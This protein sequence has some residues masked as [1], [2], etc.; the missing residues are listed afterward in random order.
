MGVKNIHTTIRDTL[1]ACRKHD[2]WLRARSPPG[3]MDSGETGANQHS[4]P[5]S[6]T[7]WNRAWSRDLPSANA[8]GYPN[9]RCLATL[10]SCQRSSLPFETKA[11]F[12]LPP[13]CRHRWLSEV[14]YP[15][16]TGDPDASVEVSLVYPSVGKRWIL[17]P[18]HDSAQHPRQRRWPA[19]A[20]SSR[21]SRLQ[22]A[23]G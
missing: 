18:A 12:D 4:D 10:L 3:L 8:G 14:P 23:T 22:I 16:G 1:L 13:P 19:R 21:V 7:D 15:Q 5:D 17:T 2:D 11:R 9:Q 20:P 6:P